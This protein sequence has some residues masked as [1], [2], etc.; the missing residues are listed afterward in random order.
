VDTDV[1]IVG[2]GPAGLA[3]AIAAR[4]KGFDVVVADAAQPP[5]DKACG[6]GLMPD[7]LVALRQLGVVVDPEVYWSSARLLSFV[8]GSCQSSARLL[9]VQSVAIQRIVRSAETSEKGTST[10]ARID[11]VVSP[12]VGSASS[13][14]AL[15]RE[16]P[17]C[18]CA[19][20]GDGTGTAITPA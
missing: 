16:R 20:L 9:L 6:E 18:G 17:R 15:S 13:A 14:I 11:D 3:A 8:S 12:I 19:E 4:L 7:S 5:I 2:G 10:F 1:F